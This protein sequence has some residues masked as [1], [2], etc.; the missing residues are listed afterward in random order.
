MKLVQLRLITYNTRQSI[1]VRCMVLYVDYCIHAQLYCCIA[2]CW[3]G[4]HRL[5]SH[6][7]TSSRRI[8]AST[9]IMMGT[10]EIKALSMQI[11]DLIAHRQKHN[12]ELEA[13]TV[14]ESRS[15]RVASARLTSR[16]NVIGAPTNSKSFV[17]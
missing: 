11:F 7:T 14:P 5:G 4:E 15:P 10:L 16:L 2:S 12:S 9:V 3:V 17:P 13:T 1:R 8:T 6:L